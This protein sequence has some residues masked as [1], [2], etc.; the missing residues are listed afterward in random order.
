MPFRAW[1]IPFEDSGRQFYLFVAIG[2]AATPEL[3]RQAW[4]VANGISFGAD[5]I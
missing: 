4:E 5:S 1:W 3:R 2:N